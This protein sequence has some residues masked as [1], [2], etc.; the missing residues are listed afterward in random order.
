[1][2]FDHQRLRVNIGCGATPTPGW[3]NLDNSPTVRLARAP[4]LLALLSAMRVLSKDQLDFAKIAQKNNI[5]WANAVRHIPLRDQVAEVVYSSHMI[6]HLN[7]LDEVPS[8]LAESRR[9]LAP[10]GFLRLAV[11][12]LFRR[13]QRYVEGCCDADDFVAS[14]HMAPGNPDT[15]FSFVKRVLQGHRNHRWMYD[16]A[17]LS[18]LLELNGFHSAKEVLPGQTT[19]PDPSP[20]DLEE[21]CAETIY[22]EARR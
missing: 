8:F 14:L 4:S 19:I 5:L 21:R 9:V 13:A 20:L 22:V 10:G 16:A 15:T 17:S 6:E 18:R 2:D 3:V 1:M 12:D 7:S 11:P